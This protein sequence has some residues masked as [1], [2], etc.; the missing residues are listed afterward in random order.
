M[1]ASPAMTRSK[2]PPA[3]REQP[4]IGM[5]LS[6]PPWRGSIGSTTGG[7]SN[8][9]ATS[10]RQSL[11]RRIIA[12]RTSQP[13]WPDS[14]KTVSGIPGA[15]QSELWDIRFARAERQGADLFFFWVTCRVGPLAASAAPKPSR[16]RRYD[17]GVRLGYRRL[18]GGA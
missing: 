16:A 13:W 7:Y 1:V 14:S 10:P 18:H 17:Q 12:N 9:S 8:R 4:A 6:T 5:R 2:L 15:V 3:L 11:R